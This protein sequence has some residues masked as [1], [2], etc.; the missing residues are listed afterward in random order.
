MSALTDSD[1]ESL[2]ALARR[3]DPHDAGAQNNLG[4]VT[5]KPVHVGGSLGRNEATSRGG[6]VVT[7]RVLERGVLRTIEVSGRGGHGV[8]GVRVIGGNAVWRAA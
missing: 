5:V 2:L 8:S 7:K 4:V 3:I 6:L 1:R